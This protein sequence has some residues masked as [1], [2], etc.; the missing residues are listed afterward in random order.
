MNN[1]NSIVEA[2]RAINNDESILKYT[3][4]LTYR[5]TDWEKLPMIEK[6][7]MRLVQKGEN[8]VWMFNNIIMGLGCPAD[9]SG[10]EYYYN[11]DFEEG[12]AGFNAI[13]DFQEELG[14][15]PEVDGEHWAY[16]VAYGLGLELEETCPEVL[17]NVLMEMREYDRD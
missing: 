4:E 3:D 10:E 9:F 11:D 12:F 7:L 15:N 5:A 1:V 13:M 6:F 8:G 16:I 14:K 17:H 2:V